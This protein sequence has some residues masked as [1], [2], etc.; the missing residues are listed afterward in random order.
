MSHTNGTTL[1]TTSAPP[2][3]LVD[4]TMERVGD[5]LAAGDLVLPRGYAWQNE[6]RGAWLM[7]QGLTMQS[8][9]HKGALVLNHVTQASVANALLDM[10]VQGLSLVRKQ[11]YL[12]P[13]GDRLTFQRSYFGTVAAARRLVGLKHADAQV[14][15]EG[16][17]LSFHVERG[18]YVIDTHTSSLNNMLTASIIAAYV[19]LTF[20]DPTLDR[21]DI[22]TMDDVRASWAQSRQAQ[23]D[24]SPHKK[25]AAEM[26]KRTVV[27]RALKALVNSAVD[28]P[29]VLEAWNRDGR[30]EADLVDAAEAE[31]ANS[32]PLE[33]DV[34]D[35]DQV[36][37][38]DQPLQA[39]AQEAPVAEDV[40]Q[41]EPVPDYADDDPDTALERAQAALPF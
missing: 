8:G 30:V 23:Y 5:L 7:L 13:Y 28:E 32:V 18:R 36:D 14:V 9:P 22:M 33:V 27:N 4:R 1:D 17:S 3:A 31:A 25:F 2:R 29:L 12:I 15:Y 40:R 6:L 37:P 19:V 34:D 20:D 11:G 21:A 39:P 35:D 16:D 38:F 24:T 10:V 26:A 41:D